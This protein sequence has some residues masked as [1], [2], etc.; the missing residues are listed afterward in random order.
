MK[1]LVKLWPAMAMRVL[2]RKCGYDSKLS[3][4]AQD[5]FLETKTVELH[6]LTSSMGRGYSLVIDRKLAL[7]FYQDGDHFVY[8]GYESGESN[9]GNVQVFDRLEVKTQMYK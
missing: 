2:A 8:D 3:E 4:K 9:P 1:W 6:P 7:F 5:L